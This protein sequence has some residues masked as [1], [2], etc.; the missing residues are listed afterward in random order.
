VYFSFCSD[1]FHYPPGTLCSLGGYNYAK[2]L[3]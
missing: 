2:T 3:M 1:Q